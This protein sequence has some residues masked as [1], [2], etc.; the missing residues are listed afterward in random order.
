[1][2]AIAKEHK[3][4]QITDAN[5]VLP[6]MKIAYLAVDGMLINYKRVEYKEPEPK[7]TQ[8]LVGIRE[9]LGFAL[10]KNLRDL[11]LSIDL[12][13]DQRVGYVTKIYDSKSN[14]GSILRKIELHTGER[15]WFVLEDNTA[16]K[17]LTLTPKGERKVLVDKEFIESI[18]EGDLIRLQ[19]IM[20]TNRK[21]DEPATYGQIKYAKVLA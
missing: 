9:A 2:K 12:I 21:K 11:I 13:E 20:N 4:K 7:P 3:I 1:M 8:L 10:P 14:S 17:S 5:D 6:N 16:R 18:V 19:L 15:F